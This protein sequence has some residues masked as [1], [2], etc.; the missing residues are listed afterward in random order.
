[1]MNNLLLA[2]IALGLFAN[3][4]VLLGRSTQAQPEPLTLIAQELHSLTHNDS[5]CQNLKLCDLTPR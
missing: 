1:M 5:G 4:W 3:L 2:A